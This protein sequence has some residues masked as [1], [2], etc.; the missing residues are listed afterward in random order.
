MIPLRTDRPTVIANFV[1]TLDGVVAFDSDGSSGGGEVSGFFDPD[2]FV[3]G[4]LRTMA[5]A[6]LVGAGT[7]RAAPT[8]E[9]TGRHVHPSS[10]AAYAHWREQIGLGS[11]QPT[12]IVATASGRLDPAHPGLSAVDVP[13][14]FATTAAGAERLAGAGPGANTRIEVAGSG[15][16][17][18]AAELL[19][20]ARSIGAGL[21]LSEGGP[22][23]TGDLLR[24]GL[25]DELFLTIAPQVAGREQDARRF[26]FVE[27]L[28]FSVADA[29]WSE[30]V[31]VRRAGDHLFLRYRFG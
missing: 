29:P 28:A 24:A 22:H 2:R 31:S 9:W 14:I 18:A 4:L 11:A 26:G 1:S 8:H 27:G 23:L 3:M 12:T 10:T 13:V 17:V 15:A 7:V 20:I 19:E 30:L 21:I 6:V 16:S 5:D 25:L